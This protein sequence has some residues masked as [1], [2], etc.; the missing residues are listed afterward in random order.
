M[1]HRTSYLLGGATETRR[2]VTMFDATVEMTHL[3]DGTNL[4]SHTFSD[5][6]QS[7]ILFRAENTTTINGTM[8]VT[9]DQG[10]VQ[11]VPVHIPVQNNLISITVGPCCN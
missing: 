1:R 5:L 10:P 4:H 7:D 3:A 6:R 8:A 9:L 11:D 2:T